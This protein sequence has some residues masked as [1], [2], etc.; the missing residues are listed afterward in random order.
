MGPPAIKG[1]SAES[2]ATRPL[3][4]VTNTLDMKLALIPAGEFKM[5]SPDS[6]K[7][8]DGD[9][10]PQH[11]VRIT[12]PFYL[13]RYEVTQ[14]QYR[15]VMNENPSVFKGSDELPVE[16]VFWLDAIKFCNKLSEREGRKPSYQIA[17]QEVSIAGGDGYRLP[18]EAEWEYACRG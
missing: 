10:R 16:N 6:Y 3:E 7:Q 1:V 14:G 12:R 11:L 4:T 18:T 15:A 9:E 5:G 13:G 17:G 2:S 8:A